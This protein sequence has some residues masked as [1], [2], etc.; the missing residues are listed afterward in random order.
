[1]TLNQI[2]FTFFTKDRKIILHF[3]IYIYF[4]CGQLNAEILLTF[5][6]I[7]GICRERK[8]EKGKIKKNTSKWIVIELN[9][10]C[11]ITKRKASEL[12]C[13]Y[14]SIIDCNESQFHRAVDICP[15]E[16]VEHLNVVGFPSTAE[17]D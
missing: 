7:A 13:N 4:W 15:L 3:A 8:S 1:M 2:E 10:V 5:D 12:I 14:N 9:F 17:R 11:S 16:A 6:F